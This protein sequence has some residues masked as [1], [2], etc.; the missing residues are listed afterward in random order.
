MSSWP[1]GAAG[2]ESAD[3]LDY[4]RFKGDKWYRLGSG[5]I[6]IWQYSAM[7]I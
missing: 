2:S 1:A 5:I 6:Y 4:S 7:S 3:A